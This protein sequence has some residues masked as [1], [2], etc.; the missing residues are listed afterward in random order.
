MAPVQIHDRQCD[1]V[2]GAVAADWSPRDIGSAARIEVVRLGA[3]EF[4]DVLMCA[5]CVGECKIF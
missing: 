5:K 1:R 3:P 2:S 4:S